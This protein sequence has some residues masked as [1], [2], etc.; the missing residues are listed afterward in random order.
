MCLIYDTCSF[1]T[2]LKIKIYYLINVSNS[3][4]YLKLKKISFHQFSFIIIN[5]IKHV[6]SLP[7]VGVMK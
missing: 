5:I 7:V 2:T 4:V 3:P 1:T 6:F